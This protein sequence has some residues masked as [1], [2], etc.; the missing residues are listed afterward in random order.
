[1]AKPIKPVKML[2]P[3][4]IKT[5]ERLRIF[6]ALKKIL[7]KY[8]PPLVAVSDYESRYELVSKK[9]TEYQ[10]RKFKVVYFGAVIIQNHYTGLYL[11]HVYSNPKMLEK[12]P[13]EL[14]KY[15]KGKC[16]FHIKTIDDK[17][18]K[19]I[20]KTVKDGIDCYKKIK[21]I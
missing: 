16:C 9:E 20:E 6:K 19:Q 2:K 8:S 3:P 11:M 4:V 18:I 12:I 14:R 13:P 15:L 17:L 5:D 7:S 10:G 21:F 1:M